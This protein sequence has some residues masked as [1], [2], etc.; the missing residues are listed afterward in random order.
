M[1]MILNGDNQ[2]TPKVKV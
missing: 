2:N 1:F